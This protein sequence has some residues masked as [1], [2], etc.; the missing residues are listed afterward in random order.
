M[1]RS[2]KEWIGKTD[3]TPVPPRVRLRV[4]GRYEHRCALCGRQIMT[5]E[6][7]VCDHKQA[8]INGGENRERNLQPICD[9]CDVKVKTPADVAEK[10]KIYDKARKHYGIKRKPK[11]RPLP[12]TYASNIKKP[13]NGPP[14]DRRTGKPIG[15]FRRPA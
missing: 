1:T 2:V 12:G 10:S 9:W 13:F 8:I 6:R 7:W 5:G 11:G 15:N 14:I 4:L 3:D